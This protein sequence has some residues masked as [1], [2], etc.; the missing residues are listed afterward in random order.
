MDTTGVL[1]DGERESVTDGDQEYVGLDFKTL[2][3]D[4]GEQ[5]TKP[6]I[7][8]WFFNQKLLIPSRFPLVTERKRASKHFKKNMLKPRLD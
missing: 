7:S 3:E 5:I 8:T 2:G 4:L 1:E 6:L